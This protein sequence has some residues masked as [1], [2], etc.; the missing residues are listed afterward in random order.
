[1]NV[2]CTRDTRRPRTKATTLAVAAS[3]AAFLAM[4]TLSVE[5][6]RAG[7][8]TTATSTATSTRECAG[9]ARGRVLSSTTLLQL[10]STEINAE[11]RQLGLPDSARYG[12]DAY[13]VRYCTIS[14]S[15]G[16][17]TASGL[18]ELPQAQRGPLPVLAYEHSTAGAKTDAPSFLLGTENRIVPLFFASDGF[19]VAAPDYLGLGVSP[20]RHP[21]MHADSEASASLDLL[22]AAD[23]LSHQWGVRLSHNVFVSGMSQGGQAAMVT[24]QALQ[25]GRGP[26]R[27]AALAPMAGPYDMSGAESTAVLDPNRTNPQRASIYLAYIFTAWKHLYHLYSDPHQVFTARYADL[28]EGLFDGTHSVGEID[29]ALPA[30]GDLFRPEIL[31]LIANPTGRYAAALRDNDACHWA[32]SAPTRLYASHGDRDVVFANAEQCRQ[33]ITASGGTAQI[34]DMGTVDHVGTAITSLPL[35]RTWFSQLA[36]G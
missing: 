25:R 14:A 8:D 13:R 10:S 30:P 34:V 29:A 35:I 27:L 3:L 36:T 19:A 16:M 28:V 26:W 33:Q 11:F 31:M 32:P 17:T 20:G 9:F 15:G 4:A 24:G 2:L 23:M 1:M 12:V 22:R 18:F 5:P 21:Y 6:A 7:P